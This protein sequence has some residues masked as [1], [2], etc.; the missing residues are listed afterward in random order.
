MI[1]GEIMAYLLQ[2]AGSIDRKV[3]LLTQRELPTD[4]PD[5]VEVLNGSWHTREIGDDELRELYRRA[6][7]VVVPLTES[8]ATLW[9]E[10]YPSGDGV[11]DACRID[12]YQRDCGKIKNC[13]MV[14]IFCLLKQVMH[15]P[16]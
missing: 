6:F 12:P 2:A 1:P 7:C 8:I 9:P 13:S 4:L 11:W 5:N 14:K 16:W 15:R 3:K 10:R